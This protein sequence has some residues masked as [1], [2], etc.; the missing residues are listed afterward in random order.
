MVTHTQAVDI[1]PLFSP[2]MQPGNTATLTHTGR[3]RR[4]DMTSKSY[5]FLACLNT[6]NLLSCNSQLL[7]QDIQSI[8]TL[9]TIYHVLHC[10]GL[11]N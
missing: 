10:W 3:Q 11:P 9:L 2:P 7:Y 1:Q 8:N 6:W 4:E 5:L